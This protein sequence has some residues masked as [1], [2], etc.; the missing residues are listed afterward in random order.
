M[1][2]PGGVDGVVEIQR[3]FEPIARVDV[4]EERIPEARRLPDQDICD[5]LE[6]LPPCQLTSGKDQTD[7]KSRRGQDH[8]DDPRSETDRRGLLFSL[9]LN[10]HVTDRARICGFDRMEQVER[11]RKSI[12]ADPWA[13]NWHDF[14][15][16]V[17]EPSAD[18]LPYFRREVTLDLLLTHV[19]HE[20]LCLSDLVIDLCLP[21]DSASEPPFV[22]PNIQTSRS[23][24]IVKLSSSS[25][26]LPGV[27]EKDSG[28]LLTFGS[29]EFP[30]LPILFH[31]GP[32][33]LPQPRA[34]R[35]HRDAVRRAREIAEVVV[36]PGPDH[37][38]V[39]DLVVPVDDD[40]A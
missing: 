34:L 18:G 37:H 7:N 30:R 16:R 32:L 38:A 8:R 1:H 17:L 14:E 9:M 40:A 24:A 15:A 35:D 13:E 23:H 39:R 2:S 11:M 29:H 5:T 25:D 22:H 36:Q 6:V 20:T 31:D 27:T 28:R 26:V 12:C 4:V 10:N 21:N 33:D 19:G 3:P